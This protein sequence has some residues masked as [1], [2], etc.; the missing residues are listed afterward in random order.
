MRSASMVGVML[1][2]LQG[3]LL[4]ISRLGLGMA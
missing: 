4:L 1:V 3:D 2:T